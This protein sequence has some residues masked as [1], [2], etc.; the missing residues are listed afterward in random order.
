[1]EVIY[2]RRIMAESKARDLAEAWAQ[3]VRDTFSS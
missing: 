1:M 3:E 2:D